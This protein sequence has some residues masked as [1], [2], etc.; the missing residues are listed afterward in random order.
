LALD[1]ATSHLDVSSERA[2]TQELSRMELT[3]LVIAHRPDT[4]AG[5]RRVVRLRAGVI[6]EV[7]HPSLEAPVVRDVLRSSIEASA[8]ISSE[9]KRVP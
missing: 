8:P 1:E 7:P 2:V 6:D 9:G 4:I 5:V 3:R